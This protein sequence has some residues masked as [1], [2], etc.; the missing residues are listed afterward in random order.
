[1]TGVVFRYLLVL[2]F[3]GLAILLQFST[4]DQRVRLTKQDV[5]IYYDEKSKTE[6][7]VASPRFQEESSIP[8]SQVGYWPFDEGIG[9]SLVMDKS[10]YQN[11]GR[12]YGGGGWTTQ[13]LISSALTFD[14]SSGYLE[15]DHSDALDL[16]KKGQS[17]AIDFWVRPQNNRL[18]TESFLGK[19]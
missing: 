19:M 16:G 14:G 9:T 13:G 10:P 12:V 3:G 18:F 4:P 5:V 11:T 2:V 15:I 17:Y 8:R 6:T 7:L 1:M